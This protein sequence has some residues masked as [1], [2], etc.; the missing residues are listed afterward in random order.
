MTNYGTA[1]YHHPTTHMYIDN[2]ACK[3]C[4]KHKLDGK[5]YGL[6]PMRDLKE[7]SFEEV[8]VDLMSPWKAQVRG[9]PYEFNALRAIDT[10][11]NLVEIVRIDKKTSDHITARFA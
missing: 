7:Q 4:Q 3:N 11:T 5:G 10:V 2:F 1:R 8:A 6:L 9:K